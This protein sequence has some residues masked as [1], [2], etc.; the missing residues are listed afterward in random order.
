MSRSWGYMKADNAFKS[1]PKLIGLLI[2]MASKGGNLLLNVGP[3]QEGTFQE[4]NLVRMKRIGKWLETNG[5]AIYGSKPWKIFGEN[6]SNSSQATDII[7]AKGFEDAVFDAT[8]KVEQDIRFT[9]NNGYLYVFARGWKMP[10]VY[11]RSIS[12]EVGEIKSVQL[13]GYKKQIKWKQTDS[14]LYIHIPDRA[15]N[16]LDIYTFKVRLED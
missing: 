3:T 4:R 11:V 2:D 9:V 15:K 6:A 7:G 8:G 14:G 12:A 13:L 5:E 1:T 16:D 10:E